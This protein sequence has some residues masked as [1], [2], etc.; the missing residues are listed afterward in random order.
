MHVSAARDYSC[1]ADSR[2]NCKSRNYIKKGRHE[3][4][5][6]VATELIHVLVSKGPYSSFLTGNVDDWFKT[7]CRI[8]SSAAGQMELAKKKK[9]SR[10]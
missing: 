3:S 4:N 8:Y 6:I 2:S 9:K 1:V 7:F 5:Q 10:L